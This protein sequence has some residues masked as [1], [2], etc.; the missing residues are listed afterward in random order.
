DRTGRIER[1]LTRDRQPGAHHLEEAVAEAA[2]EKMQAAA[3]DQHNCGRVEL[4]RTWDLA[5]ATRLLEALLCR[6]FCAFGVVLSHGQPP[7]T[8]RRSMNA[9]P[10]RSTNADCRAGRPTRMMTRPNTSVIGNPTANRLSDGAARLIT[11][12][13]RFTMSS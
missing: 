8:V 12:N 4:G 1:L 10:S 7:C 9:L 2:A 13:A 3:R 5:V 11:P 6:L